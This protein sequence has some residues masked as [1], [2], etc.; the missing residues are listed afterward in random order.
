VSPAH[1]DDAAQSAALDRVRAVFAHR[2]LS[3]LLGFEVL[4][5]APGKVT[6]AMPITPD[7]LQHTGVV[8]A[9]ATT[10]LVDSACGSAAATLMPEGK[11]VVS[12]EF[13]VNL[14]AP[15]RGRRL[16][17]EG[18]V[19]KPGRTI[20]VCTG[21]VWAEDETGARRAVALMQ[22]TMTAVEAPAGGA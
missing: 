22:A 21:D 8:H 15:A 6:L 16:V 13:K 4:E 3:S 17:A 20:F 11:A 1:L 5:V 19:V 7:V 14:L 12:I 2:S 18:R 10:A 9:G